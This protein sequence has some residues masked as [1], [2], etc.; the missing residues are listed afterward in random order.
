MSLAVFDQV[1]QLKAAPE[2]T[3]QYD[4]LF[5]F[6]TGDLLLAPSSEPTKIYPVDL[7]R[8]GGAFTPEISDPAK[9]TSDQKAYNRESSLRAL[10][11]DPLAKCVTN[12]SRDLEAQKK[13]TGSRKDW[14]DIL[15]D[16]IWKDPNNPAT[17]GSLSDWRWGVG[18]SDWSRKKIVGK[19]LIGREIGVVTVMHEL[20]HSEVLVKPSICESDLAC[21]SQMFG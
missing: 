10:I 7:T 20:I 1:G 2:S 13:Q 14:N 16:G 4:I 12:S 3:P 15:M 19:C 21:C 6:I 9:F 8:I 17:Y 5:R 11:D 18:A